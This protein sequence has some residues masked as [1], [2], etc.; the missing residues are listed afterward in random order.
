MTEPELKEVDFAS[1]MADAA[2]LR[3]R[4]LALTT[5]KYDGFVHMGEGQVPD[6]AAAGEN[7]TSG[8]EQQQDISKL[9]LDF[10]LMTIAPAFEAGNFQLLSIIG[11]DDEISPQ[12][13]AE[14]TGMAEFALRERLAPLIQSG[15]VGKNIEKGNY[16]PAANGQI[17]VKVIQGAVE[18]LAAV[19]EKELPK[20]T[21]NAQ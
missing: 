5:A 9:A 8:F 6:K 11:D 14:K 19:I 15:L 21:G 2:W 18:Q 4:S 1:A 10:L 7:S 13:L 17:L 20:L 3:L 16:V 12:S